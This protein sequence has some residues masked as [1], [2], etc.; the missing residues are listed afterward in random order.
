MQ[1]ILAY[2]SIVPL[3]VCYLS[4]LTLYL[5]GL[6]VILSVSIQLCQL[7][8]I[9]IFELISVVVRSWF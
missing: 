2:I 5:L 8:L 4:W 9:V 7:S 6:P 1:D 3:L